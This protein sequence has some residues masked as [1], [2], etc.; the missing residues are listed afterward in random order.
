MHLIP[1][2]ALADNY[3]WLLHDDQGDAVVVDPGDPQVVEHA[4]RSRQL[5]LRAILLTHHHPDHIGGA[6]ALHQ[7]HGAAIYA[8][9]D[10]RITCTTH[11]VGDGDRIE[12]T[13]PKLSFKV[14]AI[15][16]HTLTHVGYVGEGLLLCGDTLFSLGCGRLFEGTPAQMLA[17]LDRLAALPA[18]TLVCAGHE[19]TEANGRFAER[20]E[21]A[22]RRLQLRR[23]QVIRLRAARQSTLPV[24]LTEELATNPFLRV[25]TEAVIDWCSRQGVVG[26][27][28]ARFAAVREAKD[29]FRA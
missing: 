4:L 28:V 17:S 24:A 20:V 27:R 2:P 23:Q 22:N 15:P 5:Q 8:P 26:D 13:V 10:D 3:I 12:L 18:D 7:R 14:L 29:A 21:P 25:D 6:A 19:Y 1:L 16:G 11:P 9:A